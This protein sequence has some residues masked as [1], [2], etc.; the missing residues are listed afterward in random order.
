[1]KA[2]GPAKHKPTVTGAVVVASLGGIG[3]AAIGV[4]SAVRN[5]NVDVAVAARH[6]GWPGQ[7]EFAAQMN[8]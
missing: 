7:G 6:L 5:P 8:H 1:V 4:M 3:M 2:T